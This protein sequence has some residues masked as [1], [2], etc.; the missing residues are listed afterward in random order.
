MV[1]IY[2]RQN[3]PFYVLTSCHKWWCNVLQPFLW[4][5]KLPFSHRINLEKAWNFGSSK[6][7]EPCLQVD[8]QSVV[9]IIV[10]WRIKCLLHYHDDLVWVSDSAW[11]I[12][13]AA[14][15]FWAYISTSYL[16]SLCDSY[17]TLPWSGSV[18]YHYLANIGGLIQTIQGFLWII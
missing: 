17:S 7:W 9:L 3:I 10:T 11:L 14:D 2:F 8:D 6:K 1:Q 12:Q 5:G 13:V 15:Q 16:L 18:L 4:P